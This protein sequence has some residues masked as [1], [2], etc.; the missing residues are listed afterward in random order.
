MNKIVTPGNIWHSP[1]NVFWHIQKTASTVDQRVFEL[2][3]KYQPHREAKIGAIISLCMFGRLHKPTYL[4]L[5][6]PDPPDVILMQQ[7]ESKPGDRDLTL[8]EI[9]S[10]LGSP[11]ESLLSQLIRSGKTPKG[12]HKYSEYYILVVSVGV[13]LTV[14]YVE[15]RDYLNK[16]ETT[17]PIW[18]VQDVTD[19]G[20]DTLARI[21]IAN[22]E[23]YEMTIN[24]GQAV[25]E[26]DALKLPG[27]I[28]SKRAGS[29]KSV[30]AM[31]GSPD[32]RA[33]WETIGL[34]E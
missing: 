16:N 9:T 32:R 18:T 13:G 29:M 20:P 26:F 31:E 10:Y 17:F 30:R 25:Y 22:P 2:A 14:D 21:V 11:K 28:R 34:L 8:L 7:T 19:G 23:I 6:R 4:Q 15:L 1:V 3:S 27:V 5:F 12:W 33:P 24:I